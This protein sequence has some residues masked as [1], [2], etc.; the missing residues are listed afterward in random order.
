M[1]PPDRARTAGEFVEWLRLAVHDKELPAN[2]RI[3]VAAPCLGIAQ[4]HHRAIVL[5]ME[6][7]LYASSFSLLRVAF[8]AYIRGEWLALCA[9]DKQLR[10]FLRA[11]QPPPLGTMLQELEKTPA[12]EE[13]VLSS[14]K[15][16]HWDAM[17]GYTHTGGLHV[18]R[19][20]TADSIEP[21]YDPSEVE[22]VLFF[23]EI[24]GALSVIG[25]ATL[26]NDEAMA[27][28]VLE[29]IKARAA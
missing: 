21:S 22:E 11:K 20:I 28:A 12:F 18:Q 6:H 17:C 1:K 4:D 29:Q 14:L 27:L 9:T 15:K 13:Q 3:R 8:E 24:I 7:R 26:A 25:F 5:L 10:D 16:Q 19:W 23:A 2:D